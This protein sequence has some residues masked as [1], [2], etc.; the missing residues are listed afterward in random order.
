MPILS[1]SWLLQEIANTSPSSGPLLP[2]LNT[3]KPKRTV[4]ECFYAHKGR[5]IDKW[6][7][8]LEIYQAHFAKY[9]GTAVRVL[10]I[11]VD[12]GGSLQLWKA[13]FGDLAD[14]LGIDIDP[15]TKFWEPQI[16]VSIMDQASPSI[17][18]YAPFDIVIDDGSHVLSD[19]EA[20]FKALWPHCRG[21]YLIEDCHSGYPFS[22]GITHVCA[23][24]LHYYPMVMVLE[25]GLIENQPA[26]RVI[27][28]TPSRPLRQDEIDAQHLYSDP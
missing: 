14:I 2:T 16:H 27:R 18:L 17:E 21:V 28:G 26:K 12:H 4:R 5:Q 19:Q 15:Q 7:H 9:V 1:D 20:S 13:Y 23:E 3:E 8:Y 25:K 24:S 6:D 11:G 22:V 10:E